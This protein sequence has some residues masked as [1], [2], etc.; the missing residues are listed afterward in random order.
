MTK[1]RGWLNQIKIFRWAIFSL[2]NTHL[3]LEHSSCPKAAM[4]RAALTTCCPLFHM[5]TE[6]SSSLVFG[7]DAWQ[8]CHLTLKSFFLSFCLLWWTSREFSC[9]LM[10]F[11]SLLCSD[12]AKSP[13]LLFLNLSIPPSLFLSLFRDLSS[14]RREVLIWLKTHWPAFAIINL[15]MLKCDGGSLTSTL[16]YVCV[17]LP[18]LSE[19]FNREIKRASSAIHSGTQFQFQ[20][21]A[22][23]KYVIWRW[24]ST[25][26]SSILLHSQVYH[27]ATLFSALLSFPCHTGSQ[28]DRKRH[29]WVDHMDEGCISPLSSSPLINSPEFF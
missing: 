23:A 3:A 15:L 21:T 28:R 29:W 24:Q 16:L 18:L 1:A 26:L 25:F 6:E 17:C 19:Q 27:S 8:S 11:E 4:E 10:D 22:A 5:K 14:K 12:Y 13:V 7:A 20:F 9:F 2:L